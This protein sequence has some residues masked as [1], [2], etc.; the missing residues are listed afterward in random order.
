MEQAAKENEAKERRVREEE[1]TKELERLKEEKKIKEEKT[2][3]MAEIQ[4]QRLQYI[5]NFQN[6]P[7]Q[8]EP[9]AERQERA[10]YMDNFLQ[11]FWG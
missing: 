8:D 6:P 9:G 4:D 1:N 7:F 2:K 10:E 5:R 3:R 11:G